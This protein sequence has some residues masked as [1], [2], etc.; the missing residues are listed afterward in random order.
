M[1]SSGNTVSASALEVREGGKVSQNTHGKLIDLVHLCGRRGDAMEV[2]YRPGNRTDQ[3]VVTPTGD[4]DLYASVAF[5]NAVVA[6]LEGGTPR[7]VLDLGGVRYLDSSGVGALIRLLQKAKAL[8]GEVRVANLTGTPKKV[9]EMS[10]II[11]LLNPAADVETALK[12][13]G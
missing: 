7:M 12:A 3:V 11:R 13:W 8:G 9:L 10:N 5:C 2:S 1:G 6:R 4:L